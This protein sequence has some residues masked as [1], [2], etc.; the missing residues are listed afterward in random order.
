MI[1]I[2]PNSAQIVTPNCTY[3]TSTCNGGSVYGIQ[4]NV[5]KATVTLPPCNKWTISHSS[6]DRNDLTTASSAS[7]YIPTVLYNSNIG[8]SS[9]IL[10]N[11]DKFLLCHGQQYN[12][13]FAANDPDGDSLVYELYNPFTSS[14]YGFVSYYFPYAYTNFMSSIPY[15]NLDPR[16]GI[17][18]L[19]PLSLLTSV[20]GVRITEWRTING[21]PTVVGERYRDVH[22]KVINCANT[23]PQLAGFD[24]NGSQSYNPQDSVFHLSIC[25]NSL[26]QINIYGNDSDLVD[27]SNVGTK[28]VFTLSWNQGISG[29]SF[30]AHD[31]HTDS[32]YATFSWTPTTADIQTSPH[33]FDVEVRDDACPFYGVRTRTYCLTVEDA[34][35][36]LFADTILCQGDS[37][38]AF[39]FNSLPSSIYQWQIDGVVLNG[40]IQPYLKAYTDQ[41]SGGF[42]QLEVEAQS[43]IQNNC[44]AKDSIL[45]ELL[46]KP[47]FSLGNDTL[48]PFG[49]SYTLNAPSG[50][51]NFFW[52]T[53]ATSSS[54]VLDS[55]IGIWQ[56]EI[57]LKASGLNNGCVNTD[58][59]QITFGTVGLNAEEESS[60][61]LYPNPASN[62]VYIQN[63][64]LL[65]TSI[66]LYQS[67]GRLVKRVVIESEL[68]EIDVSDFSPGLYYIVTDS[69]P[70]NGYKLIVN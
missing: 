10:P 55:T 24:V 4:E 36:S 43:L 30:Q 47:I 3:T 22:V 5:Y 9:P 6:A 21:V 14:M 15:I 62:T 37:L 54:I 35:L 13:S 38:Y 65:G 17:L 52:S 1:P 33:C 26:F 60:I 69:N 58:T 32:A 59:I 53:G 50:L 51:Y 16:T 7:Y 8:N 45:F 68:T 42:H 11:H 61:K 44:V 48:L 27:T 57:W 70:Y 12:I 46:P 39:S 67:D 64:N 66:S 19:R 20:Y 29:A 40:E 25:P 49:A 41:L 18:S 63:A 23:L 2:L 28:E 56:N 34:Q 31:S